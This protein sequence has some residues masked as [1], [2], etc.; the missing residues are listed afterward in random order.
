MLKILAISDLFIKK[1]RLESELIAKLSK[2]DKI[3]II[4]ITNDW[5]LTP[6]QDG[7]EVKEYVG[8]EEEIVKA[9][10][11]VDLILTHVGPITAKV[12]R[13]AGHLRA[14][15]VLRGGP[16]NVNIQAATA[17]KVPVLNAP[18]RNAPVVAEF[19]IAMILSALR[20]IPVAH[21]DL[22]KGIWRGDFYVYEKSGFE[23]PGRTAGLIGF[24]NIGSRVSKLLQAF[25]MHVLVYDP[26]V[27]EKTIAQN[28]AAKVDLDTLLQQA[29]IVS[30]HVRLSSE[31][32]KMINKSVFQKMK[33]TALFVNTA[34]GGLVNYADLVEALKE[35]IIGGAALDVYE[36]EPLEPGNPLL[37]LENVVLTPHI[38]GS[39]ME[40]A[41]RGVSMVIDDFLRILSGQRPLYCM[42]P[43]VL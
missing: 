25:G 24:G 41:H 6:P 43:E 20:N 13:Q 32:K 29:D 9:A 28:G 35:G 42:N 21:R 23:L 33:P 7:S 37:E 27:D 17:L 11:G 1:E 30:V 8:S 5:P 19:T 18:G 14:I 34:R 4:H 15:G 10:S 40:T 36:N 2:F 38:G 3:E 12:M 22:K 39:S 16:V 26:Y 31:T